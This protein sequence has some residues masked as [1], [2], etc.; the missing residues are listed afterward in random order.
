MMYPGK[1]YK[2]TKAAQER[3]LELDVKGH[4]RQKIAEIINHEFP[5]PVALTEDAVTAKIWR[6]RNVRMEVL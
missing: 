2:W 3:A 1:L 6:M 4:S 5:Q